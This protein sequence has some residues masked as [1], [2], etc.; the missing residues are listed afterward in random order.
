M[1]DGEYV[2]DPKLLTEAHSDCFRRFLKAV[3]SKR[4]V[5]DVLIVDNTNMTRWEM[6]PYVTVAQS[7]NVAFQVISI[8]CPAWLSARR[9]VHGVPKDTI[10]RMAKNYE[11]ALPWWNEVEVQTEW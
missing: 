7:F 5:A 8:M 1:H 9:N 10:E 6:A 4:K 11:P 2:F 3:Q